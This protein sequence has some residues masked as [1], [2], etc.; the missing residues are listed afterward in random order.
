M[1]TKESEEKR[2]EQTMISNFPTLAVVTLRAGG[3]P[4]L[5]CIASPLMS[6]ITHTHT[7]TQNLN[8]KGTTFPSMKL[9][10]L[11]KK[12]RKEDLD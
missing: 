2:R 3:K 6:A 5:A 12:K 7:Q 11:L 8:H 1:F 9:N 10:P 4:I